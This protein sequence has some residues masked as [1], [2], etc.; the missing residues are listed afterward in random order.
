M[1]SGRSEGEDDNEKAE[2][3]MVKILPEALVTKVSDTR[4][5]GSVP[6]SNACSNRLAS[7]H[8]SILY[9]FLICPAS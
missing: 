1:H 7:T 5:I 6:A 4:N 8:S 3:A 9:H 2:L